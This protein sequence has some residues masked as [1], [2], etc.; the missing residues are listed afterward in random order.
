MSVLG[1]V[2][3]WFGSLN[4]P[5]ARDWGMEMKRLAAEIQK[6]VERGEIDRAA[7]LRALD[8]VHAETIRRRLSGFF[9]I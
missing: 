6:R 2:L 7:V 4:G 5:P 1:P 9:F 8:E 3:L